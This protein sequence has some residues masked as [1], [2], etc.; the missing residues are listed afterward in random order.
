MYTEPSAVLAKLT[1]IKI[2]YF[3]KTWRLRAETQQSM[4]SKSTT[5]QQHL[6]CKSF[7]TEQLKSL[8]TSGN[9]H[10]SLTPSLHVISQIYL[11][12]GVSNVKRDASNDNDSCH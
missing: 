5:K 7:K 9:Y 8:S 2:S 12:P 6:F 11:I 3:C 10:G 4:R 1:Q